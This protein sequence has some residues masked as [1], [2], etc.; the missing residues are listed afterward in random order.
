MKRFT[1][2][3]FILAVF[4][5]GCEKEKSITDNNTPGIELVS[6]TI[7]SQRGRE[8]TIKGTLTDPIG[9]KSVNIYNQNWYLDKTIVLDHDTTRTSYD[10]SYTFLVPENSADQEILVITLTNV[11]D[12]TNSAN[13]TVIMDGDF[14]APVITVNG[15]VS[16]GATI[17][18]VDGDVFDLDFTFTDERGL[19][20][21]TVKESTLG[22]NDSIGG[23]TG[24]SYNYVNNTIKM[25]VKAAS[26]TFNLVCADTSGNVTSLD[27]DVTISTSLDYAK[28]YLVDVSTVEELNSDLFGVPMLIDKTAPFTYEALYFCET[29]NTA[30]RFIPQKASFT[31]VCYGVD[32]DNTSKLIKSSD[33][34]GI[35]LPSV[36]YYK[37]T[38]CIDSTVLSYSVASFDPMAD[39]DRPDLYEQVLTDTGGSGYH[40]PLGLVG[41][42]FVD[43]PNMSWSPAE[44]KNYPDL[45]LKQDATYKYRWTTT[46]KLSGNVQ[47]IISPEHPWGWWQ[48]PFWRFDNKPDP[49][50]TILKGGDNVDINVATETTYKF[51]FDQYL[52]R[53]KM[54]RL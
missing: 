31:P 38:I 32:P 30:V 23:L 16:D 27:I 34:A 44:V 50:Y 12:K 39:A 22:L 48:D 26:Y 49:E 35:V 19:S 42:G 4:L 14:D 11:G 53:V 6:S 5:S 28:M 3:L 18:P 20:Y 41:K 21:V 52:N 54:V 15:S 37:I 29:A 45:Q 47:F 13:L 10:L 8:I 40:G 7:H 17:V 1:L 9:L 25:P 36:G 51:V 43:C 46:V 33:A 24:T 2:F